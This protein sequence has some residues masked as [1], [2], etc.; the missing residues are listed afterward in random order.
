MTNPD[1]SSLIQNAQSIVEAVGQESVYVYLF[2]CEEFVKGP[3]THN[4]VFQFV[5]RSFYRLDNAGLT[6]EFKSAYFDLLERS[7]CSPEVDLESLSRKL[8]DIPNRKGQQSLQ[9]SFVTKLANTISPHYPIYDSEVAK[10]LGFRAPYN[11]K[12]FETRLAEYLTFYESLRELYKRIITDGILR[13]PVRLFNE[14]YAPVSSRVPEVK[15]LDFIFWSAG[16]LLI[17]V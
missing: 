2:L 1:L 16:K 17:E 12:A 11:Y 13:E 3:V 9:F 4:H 6:P 7:R 8:Y 14:K 15:V 5:Y 10:V